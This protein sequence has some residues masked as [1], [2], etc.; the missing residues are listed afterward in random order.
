M[1]YLGCHHRQHVHVLQY[2]QLLQII[3]IS[4]A[5]TVELVYEIT[6]PGSH[7]KIPKVP[8]HCIVFLFPELL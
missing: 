7:V 6:G 8:R 2:C 4:S 3:I 1:L 5:Q